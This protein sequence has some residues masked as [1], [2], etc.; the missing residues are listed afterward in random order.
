MNEKNINDDAAALDSIAKQKQEMG[1]GP[2]GEFPE[3]QETP[4]DEGAMQF[5]IGTLNG[6]VLFN[7]GKAVAWFAMKPE[8]ARE[9]AHTILVLADSLE[10]LKE[11][12]KG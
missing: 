6:K 2:T 7:F 3:G 5:G 8:Q 4:F 1:L 12:G 11:N 9:A 10:A